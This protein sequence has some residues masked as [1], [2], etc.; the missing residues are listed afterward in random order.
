MS[1][2]ATAVQ[3]ENSWTAEKTGCKDQHQGLEL[4]HDA[5]YYMLISLLYIF[6][7]FRP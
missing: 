5:N 6:K 4:V 2:S 1:S 7:A 3:D